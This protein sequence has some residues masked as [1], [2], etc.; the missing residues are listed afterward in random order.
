MP[1][2]EG[3]DPG[4][5]RVQAKLGEL[6]APLAAEVAARECI[7]GDYVDCEQDCTYADTQPKAG[8]MPIIQDFV[9]VMVTADMANDEQEIHAVSRVGQRNH[10]TKGLLHVA[11]N[12]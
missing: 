10:I 2:A 9:L 1:F 3:N 6:I 11:L 12:E 8:S 7:H 4:Y 5:E